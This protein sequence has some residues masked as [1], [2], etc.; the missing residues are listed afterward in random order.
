M[1]RVRKVL[2]QDPVQLSI[3]VLSRRI[4]TLSVILTGMSILVAALAVCYQIGSNERGPLFGKT[5]P[6]V[7]VGPEITIG[8]GLWGWGLACDV[9]LV[10]LGTRAFDVGR[11]EAYLAL[12]KGSPEQRKTL[13]GFSGKP[14][15]SGE[16]R[17]LGY[18]SAKADGGGWTGGVT[19]TERRSQSQ[20]RRTGDL[21][22]R[23]FREIQDKY[24]SDNEK[25]LNAKRLTYE[26]SDALS[27]EMRSTV[28]SDVAWIEP[29]TYRLLISIP[30]ADKKGKF[31]YRGGFSFEVTDS[32]VEILSELQARA[33]KFPPEAIGN[34]HM[35]FQVR[36]IIEPLDKAQTDRLATEADRAREAAGATVAP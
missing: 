15:Y 3:S 2:P 26:V 30:R 6:R 36:P 4:Q 9:A 13:L 16:W 12:D 1:S 28:A 11:M 25:A 34:W 22:C 23:V 18:F 10:N 19:F 33:Y 24:F 32:N 7:S 5:D 35:S 29:G 31:V 21:S 8:N 14:W 17:P 27:E 20:T